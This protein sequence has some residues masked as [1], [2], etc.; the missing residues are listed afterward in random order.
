MHTEDLG[1]GLLFFKNLFKGLTVNS[2][3]GGKDALA[4]VIHEACE[5][6]KSKM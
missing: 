2:H 6:R 3:S 1:K 4:H 5:Y